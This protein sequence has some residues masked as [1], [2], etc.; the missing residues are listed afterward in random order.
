MGAAAGAASA[1]G[2]SVAAYPAICGEVSGPM[3]AAAGAAS[4]SGPSVDVFSAT[5]GEV[6]GPAGAAAGA[7]SVAG[8]S[9]GVFSATCGGVPGPAGAAAGAVAAAAVSV[10]AF[11]AICGGIPGPAGAVADVVAAAAGAASA[12]GASVDVSGIGGSVFCVT[13]EGDGTAGGA[14][15]GVTECCAR[16]SSSID[17]VTGRP[18]C[19]QRSAR[20]DTGHPQRLQGMSAMVSPPWFGFSLRFGA[21]CLAGGENRAGGAKR[22]LRTCTSAPRQHDKGNGF[23]RNSPFPPP[24]FFHPLPVTAPRQR[25]SPPRHPLCRLLPADGHEKSGDPYSLHFLCFT[26]SIPRASAASAT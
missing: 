23:F 14:A 10:A 18:Q 1:S 26:F 17:S 3:G 20:V 11:P 9:V 19:G 2:P 4:A 8:A 5:C 25:P 22:T 13:G 24:N 12:A 7:A 16:V 15:S 21:A 6:S